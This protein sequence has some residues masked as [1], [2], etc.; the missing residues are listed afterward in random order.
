V[1][2]LNPMMNSKFDC[3]FQVWLGKQNEIL[4]G[5]YLKL[6]PNYLS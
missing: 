3:R 4:E 5:S 1:G 6:I 2:R